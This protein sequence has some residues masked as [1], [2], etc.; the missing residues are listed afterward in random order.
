M[1]ELWDVV[2]FLMT[3]LENGAEKFTPLGLMRFW[4]HLPNSPNVSSSNPSDSVEGD[5]HA[6]PHFPQGD[7]L[8][9]AASGGPRIQLTFS[10]LP[11]NQDWCRELRD[12]S[13][14]IPRA[15]CRW[16]QGQQGHCWFIRV[17]DLCSPLPSSN[18][19]TWVG[20]W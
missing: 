5:V 6:V 16:N 18:T 12:V 2:G 11:L 19:C 20:G 8:Y 7:Y 1:T 9:G 15:A 10:L 17:W 3:G 4:I 14:W 13:W